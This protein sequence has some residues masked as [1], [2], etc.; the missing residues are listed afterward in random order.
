MK[1]SFVESPYRIVTLAGNQLKRLGNYCEKTATAMF[2]FVRKTKV[3]RKF[4]NSKVEEHPEKS[5]N[6]GVCKKGP[7]G[8]IDGTNEPRVLL[9]KQGIAP[10]SI[11]PSV[12]SSLVCRPSF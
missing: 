1:L 12:R 7:T 6:E 10:E 9:Q 5:N 11:F 3:S 4:L 2:R 8:S